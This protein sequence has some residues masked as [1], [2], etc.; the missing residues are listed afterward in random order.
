MKLVKITQK[1][2][3]VNENL[4][5]KEKIGHGRKMSHGM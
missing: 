4:L 1:Y 3:K 2:I 5:K